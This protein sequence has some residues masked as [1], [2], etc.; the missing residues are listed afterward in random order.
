MAGSA[1]LAAQDHAPLPDR[2]VT[3]KAV[4]LVNDSVDLKA[5]DRFYQELKKWNRFTIVTSRDDA[6]IVMVLTSNSQYV[7]S[8]VTGTAVTGGSVI[9]TAVSVPSTSLCLKV[10]DSATAEGLWSDI[11]EKWITSGHA[12]STLVSNLKKRMPTKTK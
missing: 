4:Y 9:G 12:P 7:V 2:L 5:F 10:F 6:E 11:T 3:A 1:L 8:V